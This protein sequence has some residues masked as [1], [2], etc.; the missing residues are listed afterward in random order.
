MNK[1]LFR[2]PLICLLILGRGL[3]TV[4]A[5]APVSPVSSQEIK[6]SFEP[7][8]KV[9]SRLLS[10]DFYQTPMMSSST[11]DPF[12]IDPNWKKGRVRVDGIWFENISLRFDI[13]SH[14]II[15]NTVDLTNSYMQVILKKDR[16]DYFTMGSHSF[17]TFPADDPSMGKRFCELMVSGPIEFLVLKTKNLKVTAGGLSDYIYQTTTQKNL[18]YQGELT[19]YTGRGTLIRKFPEFKSELKDF[20]KDNKL[21]FRRLDLDQHAMLISYCNKLIGDKQ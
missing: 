19:R 7:F 6:K 9:D 13:S 5:Q 17:I 8:F 10:G 11:G 16:I 18:R 3:M 14:N 21:I 4:A 15:L 1:A 12:F 20:I 2:L